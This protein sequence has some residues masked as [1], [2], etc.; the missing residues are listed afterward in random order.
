[1]NTRNSSVSGLDLRKPRKLRTLLLWKPRNWQNI[2]CVC[3]LRDRYPTALI[4]RNIGHVL[5]M[6]YQATAEKLVVKK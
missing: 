3:T 1:M 4:N 5:S 2:R 6:K